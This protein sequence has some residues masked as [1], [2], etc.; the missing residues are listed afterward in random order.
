MKKAIVT[1]ALG[2]G[3]MVGSLVGGSSVGAA[4]AGGAKATSALFEA[5]SCSRMYTTSQLNLRT[6]PG[7]DYDVILVMDTGATVTVSDTV[8]GRQNGFARVGYN[9]NYGWASLDYLFE[10]DGGGEFDTSGPDYAIV[11]VGV[12]SDSVNFRVGPGTDYAVQD[13]LEAGEQV[14][15]SDEVLNGF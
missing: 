5:C 12:T 8:E 13:Y 15:Y 11:D 9:G 1:A 3:V 14:A 6:G 10:V 7:T 2:F 4:P